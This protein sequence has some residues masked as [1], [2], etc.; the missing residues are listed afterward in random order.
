M[1]SF[2]LLATVLFALSSNAFAAHQALWT[3]DGAQIEG[4]GVDRVAGKLSGSLSWDCWPGGG[5]CDAKAEVTESKDASG[6]TVFRGHAFKLV[7]ET[8]SAPVDGA[9]NAHLSATDTTDPADSGRGFKFDDSVT[10]RSRE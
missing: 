5:I 10:C 1:K 6:D 4:A 7:I 8:S 2:A 3:C 9:Y